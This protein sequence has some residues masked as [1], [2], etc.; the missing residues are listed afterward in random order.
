MIKP[1]L[2]RVT[3]GQ[4]RYVAGFAASIVLAFILFLRYSINGDLN[5]DEAIYA[6]AGQQLARGVP[7]YQSIFDPKGPLASL[8]LGL[9]AWIGQLLSVNGI[10]AMRVLFLLFAVAT[11][12][13]IYVLTLRLWGSVSAAL[14]AAFVFATFRGWAADAVAGPDAK[15]PSVFFVVLSMYLL[16]RRQ[17]FWGGLVGSLAVLVWQPLLI[18]PIL[19]IV[20]AF[21]FA[22]AG[23]RWRAGGIALGG[24]LLPL[25]LTCVYFAVAGAFGDFFASA[26]AYPLTGVI[27]PELTWLGRVHFIGHIVWTW[28]QASGVL[29]W[30]GAVLFVLVVI[31]LFGTHRRSPRTAFAN[32]VFCV[33]FISAIVNFGYASLDFQGYPD[34]FPLLPYAALGLGGA[35]ALTQRA[36]RSARAR[37]AVGAVATV[38][39]LVFAGFSWTWFG[40]DE[41]NNHGLISQSRTGCGIDR[42]ATKAHPFWAFGDPI[43]LV[44]SHRRNPDRYIYLNQGIAEWRV[45]HDPGGFAAWRRQ[46]LQAHPS[47]VVLR[48]WKGPLRFK[49]QAAL[50]RHHYRPFAI[51]PYWVLVSPW[52]LTRAVS[53]GVALTLRP[54]PDAMNVHTGRR[55]PTAPCSP[56]THPG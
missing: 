1:R 12:A 22:P 35:V 32:P 6:Y 48:T 8:L 49:M 38:A 47:V 18:F 11:V 15:M 23:A 43:M 17:W 27:A 16:A 55:L 13:M 29:F 28:Y 30:L 39:A 26:F 14:S 31:A 20:L 46:V 19:A 52:G 37:A 53:Q 25:C 42:I 21:V 41:M 45:M 24:G 51:G 3:A 50:H 40:S 56:A 54:V 4:W 5:R 36:L 34:L 9:A 2:A 33:V 44:T 7:P 10:Y